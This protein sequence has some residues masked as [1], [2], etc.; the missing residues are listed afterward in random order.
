VSTVASTTSGRRKLEDSNGGICGDSALS[1]VIQHAIEDIVSQYICT[2]CDLLSHYNKCDESS[3]NHYLDIDMGDADGKAMALAMRQ[4]D[5][6]TIQQAAIAAIQSLSDPALVE[7]G[8][9][10]FTHGDIELH[11]LDNPYKSTSLYNS[12]TWYKKND[13]TKKK[14]C[15]W[16]A[17]WPQRC[18][19][20][21]ND[22]TTASYSCPVACSTT[23]GANYDWY[24]K[25][26]VQ[27]DCYWV[28]AYAEARCDVKGADGTFA[29]ESCP[30]ACLDTSFGLN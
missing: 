8:V 13:E 30:A 21:G 4:L 28:A 16:V 11:A 26:D 2:D 10:Y 1:S 9:A 19:A 20:K 15:D 17:A 27:K 22:G 6:A 7:A 14:N 18:R 5:A 25:A 3:G 12:P 23:V 24:K 29:Y